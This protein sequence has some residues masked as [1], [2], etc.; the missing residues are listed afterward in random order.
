MIEVVANLK[1]MVFKILI[2][3][4]KEI[5][6]KR[7]MLMVRLFVLVNFYVVKTSKKPGYK[8]MAKFLATNI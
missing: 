8:H 6:L 4:L 2:D 7:G 5:G 3:I 1:S